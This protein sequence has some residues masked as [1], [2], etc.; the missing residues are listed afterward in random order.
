MISDSVR[1]ASLLTYFLQNEHT[2]GNT[3]TGHGQHDWPGYVVLIEQI[4]HSH[5]RDTSMVTVSHAL[6]ASTSCSE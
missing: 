5:K 1:A 6:L 4:L 3:T 2:L